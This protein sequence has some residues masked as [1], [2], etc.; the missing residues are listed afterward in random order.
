MGETVSPT[1]LNS[2]TENPQIT[3]HANEKISPINGMDEK[4][5]N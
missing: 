2:T 3:A 5:N 1:F 4:L